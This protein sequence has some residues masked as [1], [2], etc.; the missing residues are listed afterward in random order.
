MAKV[1]DK[2]KYFTFFSLGLFLGVIL[3]VVFIN[4]LVSYRIDSYIKEIKYLKTTID[5]EKARL[6]KLEEAIDK[7]KPLVKEI[8]VEL[9][10]P[11]NEQDD[12]VKIALQKH[13]KEK[14]DGII[15]KDVDKIDG[16]ILCQMLDKRI[17]KLDGKEYQLKIE[18]IIISQEIKFWIEVR[19]I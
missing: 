12:I 19:V 2:S 15:G 1:E 14:F 7:K 13:I 9:S 18:K 17:M 16:D 10:F 5:E 6:E 11:E 3:G 8:N 4:L